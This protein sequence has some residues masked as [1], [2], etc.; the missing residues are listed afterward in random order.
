M[1][2][3]LSDPKS[4]I[5][6]VLQLINTFSNVSGYKINSNKPVAFLY[7]QDKKGLEEIRETTPFAI[8]T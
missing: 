4:S 7:T 2:I 5:R 8:D 1:I 6:E 3:F